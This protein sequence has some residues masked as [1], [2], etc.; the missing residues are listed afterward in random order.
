MT[1]WSARPMDVGARRRRVRVQRRSERGQ[2]EMYSYQA[3]GR[4]AMNRLWVFP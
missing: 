2:G 1:E 4:N 3:A